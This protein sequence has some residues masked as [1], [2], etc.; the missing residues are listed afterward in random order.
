MFRLR[1]KS[2]FAIVAQTEE[3]ETQTEEPSNESDSADLT[4]NAF[5]I[6]AEESG[7]DTQIV[8]TPTNKVS[9][10]LNHIIY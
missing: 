3:A 4:M 6:S 9:I 7:N 10:L 1:S 5:G 8:P 2:T